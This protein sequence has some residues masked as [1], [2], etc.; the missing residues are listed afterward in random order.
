MLKHLF[1]EKK[2]TG[3]I[4]TRITEDTEHQLFEVHLNDKPVDVYHSKEDAERAVLLIEQAYEDGLI[5]GLLIG[6][7]DKEV[8]K[9]E[10]T[11]R[12]VTF[13]TVIDF[14]RQDNA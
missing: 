7:K 13:E 11:A 3:V 5:N 8:A 14:D 6:Y 12:G 4:T 9:K 10:L 2:G 1:E